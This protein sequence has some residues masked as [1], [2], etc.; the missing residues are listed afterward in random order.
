M[1]EAEGLGQDNGIRVGARP[2]LIKHGHDRFML[3][4]AVIGLRREP[5]ADPER[6]RSIGLKQRKDVLQPG[7][8]LCRAGNRPSLAYPQPGQAEGGL[9]YRGHVAGRHRELVGPLEVLPAC[10]QVA[11]RVQRAIAAYEG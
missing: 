2:Y 6:E 7:F 8:Q 4:T 1:R 9:G 10:V 11:I 3:T 5:A